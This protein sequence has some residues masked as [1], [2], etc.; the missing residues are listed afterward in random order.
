MNEFVIKK[1]QQKNTHVFCV[2]FVGW[3]VGCFFRSN[4]FPY[5]FLYIE[6]LDFEENFLF[7]KQKCFSSG[8]DDDGGGGR[9][10]II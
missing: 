1:Q 8:D 9:S 7:F 2:F 4:F 5:R 10:S 3:L 6:L